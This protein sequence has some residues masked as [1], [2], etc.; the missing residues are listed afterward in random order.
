MK[1]ARISRPFQQN[2]ASDQSEYGTSPLNVNINGGG[3]GTPSLWAIPDEGDSG[4][5]FVL[6]FLST[7]HN[8]NPRMPFSS[9]AP[10]G[11]LTLESFG[12]GSALS[13]GSHSLSIIFHSIVVTRTVL[14]WI[15]PTLMIPSQLRSI[16]AAIM[17]KNTLSHANSGC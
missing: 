5:L 13:H 16:G 6:P 7:F 2:I 1:W 11:Y 10:P 17:Y 12:S 8:H 4:S 3:Y 9:R 14:L 15:L